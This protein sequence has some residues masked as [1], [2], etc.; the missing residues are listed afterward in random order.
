MSIS[1]NRIESTFKKELS[2][3]LENAKN[4]YLKSMTITDIDLTGQKEYARVYFMTHRN[5]EKTLKEVKRSSSY[6]NK[7]LSSKL[8]LKKLPK[9]EFI[10][11]NS[12]EY[13]KEI[14][15]KLKNI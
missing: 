1:L 13:G 12:Y 8:S 14:E 3:I 9:I 10:L 4:D 5:I 7:V 11:D 2:Y 15:E 6:I